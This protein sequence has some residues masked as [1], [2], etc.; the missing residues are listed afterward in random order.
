MPLIIDLLNNLRIIFWRVL[1]V[2]RNFSI[3][4]YLYVPIILACVFSGIFYILSLIRMSE[5]VA[6][7]GGVAGGGGDTSINKMIDVISKNR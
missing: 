2:A 1:F 4:A 5:G 6:G 7:A 3:V